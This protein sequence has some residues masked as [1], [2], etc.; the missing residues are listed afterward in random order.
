MIVSTT[1]NKSDR[2]NKIKKSVSYSAAVI[3]WL[4]VW[5]M[6]SIRINKAVVLVSPLDV[7]KTLFSLVGEAAFWHTVMF[8]FIRISGG[9]FAALASGTILAAAAARYEFVR[10]LLSPLTAAVKATPVAS[11][12]ILALLWMP[13]RQLAVF[14]SFL[15]VFPV[16]YTNVLN[17][18]M[19]VDKKLLE[20][21]KVYKI[22]P[23]KKL[24]YIYLPDVMPFFV[25]ACT[26]SLGLCWKSGIAAEVIGQPSGSIGDRLYRA[27]IYLETADLFAWTLV[28]IVI[29]AAFER[30]FLFLLKLLEKKIN[31]GGIK[32]IG[33][34]STAKKP[35]KSNSAPI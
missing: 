6:A 22:P 2:K 27:K 31:K 34:H 32:N 30:V 29:S 4:A 21:A 16:M 24:L 10:V 35:S 25:S 11:F 1:S 20:M 33:C 13:S 7:V 18:I 26:V 19:N 9:F 15:M 8:S 28:I 5:H 12:V 23:L 3:F 17:G 14:I